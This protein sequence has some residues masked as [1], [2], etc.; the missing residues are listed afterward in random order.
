MLHV[1]EYLTKKLDTPK[2][3]IIGM[4][5]VGREASRKALERIGEI[6][7]FTPKLDGIT[8]KALQE[9]APLTPDVLDKLAPLLTPD[10]YKIDSY[11]NHYENDPKNRKKGN[12]KKRRKR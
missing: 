8:P 1:I 10:S 5:D 12:S 2:V 3:V 6:A 9:L 7:I 11:L 4:D